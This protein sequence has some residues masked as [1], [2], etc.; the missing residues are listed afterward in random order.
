[1]SCL[2]LNIIASMDQGNGLL[3]RFIIYVPTSLRPL[4]DEQTAAQATVAEFNTSSMTTLYESMLRWDDENA[5][6]FYFS[7]EAL[8]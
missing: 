2:M 8:K 4:P 5:P 6:Q 3:D 1:M 7:E